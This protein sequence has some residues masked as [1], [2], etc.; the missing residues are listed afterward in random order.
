MSKELLAKLVNADGVAGVEQEVRDIMAGE[1]IDFEISGDNIGSF[2]AYKK[3]KSN[4][5]LM[6]AG[7]LDEVGFMV[8]RITEEGFI[9]MKPVGGWF[10][11]V[12]L[13]Q[14]FRIT[15]RSGKKIIGNIA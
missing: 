2:V 4:V 1:L 8:A 14:K 13:A 11:Q 5:K 7:H 9:Y 3:G 10:S 12:V 15:T 6:L